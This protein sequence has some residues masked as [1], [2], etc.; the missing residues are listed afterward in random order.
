MKP[1]GEKGCGGGQVGHGVCKNK[2]TLICHLLK[3]KNKKL[4]SLSFKVV[5]SSRE[6]FYLCMSKIC[7]LNELKAEQDERCFVPVAKNKAA[8]HWL[9]AVTH[10]RPLTFLLACSSLRSRAEA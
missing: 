6:N 7:S 9:A 2:N 5:V 8:A 10:P 3:K 1:G 4:F